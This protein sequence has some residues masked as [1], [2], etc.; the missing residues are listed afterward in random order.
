MGRP[1]K[2]AKAQAVLT[3]TT[4]VAA[5][6]VITVSGSLTTAGVIAG[7]PFIPATT[8][9]GLTGGTT[10]YVLTVLSATTFTAS[11]TELSA[12]T[13]Q[14]VVPLSDTTAQTVK[15]TVG[16]V[17]S[18]FNNPPG[19]SY[20]VVGG[21]TNLYGKQ[22]LCNV[23]IGQSGTGTIYTSNADSNIYGVGTD[24]AN[25][26]ASGSAIQVLTANVNG[27]TNATT[28][29]FTNS[30]GGYVT[31]TT[32]NVKA[33][34]DFIRTSAGNCSNL[35]SG[36]PIVFTASVGP[37]V[38]GTVYFAKTLTNATALNL[39]GVSPTL[40]STSTGTLTLFNTGL[41]TVNAFGAATTLS[42][43]AATGTLTINNANTVITGNLTVNGTTTTINST[44][45]SVDDIEAKR[46][47]NIKPK[48]GYS[49]FGYE[50]VITNGVL[51]KVTKGSIL[52]VGPDSIV[53]F[54]DLLNPDKYST[55]DTLSIEIA[56]KS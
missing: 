20:G 46:T 16:L 24:F 35:V 19:A 33:T 50:E 23:A 34:G 53:D 7:M 12:N 27:S 18:G 11:A 5:T 54:R 6:D 4:T 40:A 10:Y 51:T 14:T 45:T 43:G 48:L 36:A 15:L 21:N 26:L 52:N 30:T 37:L 42:I 55:G 13:S 22:I 17:G 1:L 44:I 56:M 29:G 9:G 49:A 39:N 38:A 32:A 3:L 28:I 31:V 25:T 8:V 2:I 47:L 41:T